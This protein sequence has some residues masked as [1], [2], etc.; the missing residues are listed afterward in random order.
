[1]RQ[2]YYIFCVLFLL[3]MVVPTP[4]QYRFDRWTTDN[5][6]P[7][8]T[9]SQIVQTS[10]GYL[11]FTTLDG[12]V[13]FDGVRFTVFNKSNSKNLPSNRFINLFAE[14][15]DTLWISTEEHGLVR[16]RHGE[17]QN[18]TTADGLPFNSNS[19]V[20]I[21][22]DGNIYAR[23]ASSLAR[24]DGTRFSLVKSG[25]EA[26]RSK[27]FY[28]PSGA[29]W[30]I[31]ENSLSVVRNGEKSVFALSPG[32]KTEFHPNYNFIYLVN[33]FEDRD[34]ALWI[35]T[36]NA[37]SEYDSGKL[38]KFAGGKFEQ[39]TADGMPKSLAYKMVQDRHGNLWIGTRSDGACRLAQ[40]RFTCYNAKNQ[41]DANAVQGIFLDR[42]GTLWLS[43]DGGGLYRVGEQFI[44]SLS[45]KEGLAKK[46][47]YPIY[48]DREGAIWIGSSGGLARYKDGK[49]TNYGSKEGLIASEIQSLFE[50]REGRLWIGGFN[51]FYYLKDGNFLGWRELMTS[52]GF[53]PTFDIHQDRRGILWFATTIGLIRYDGSSFKKFT[54]DDGLPGN[55]VKIILENDDGTFWLGT[56]SGLALM[57]DDKFTVYTDKDGLVGN[58]I[59]SLYKDETGTLWI[60][61]YDSGLSR[62]KDGKFTNYTIENGLASN[63]VFQ[64][65][66]DARRNFWISSNQGIY[67]VNR[68]E[69][70]EFAEGRRQF[71]TSTLYGKSDGMLTTEANGGGQP[72]GLKTK[73]GRLWFPTQD[74]VAVIDPEA[75]KVNPLP[76]PV[77]IENARIDNQ[78]IGGL[79]NGIEMLPGQENLE[80]DYTGLS[81]IRPEQVRFRYRLEGFDEKWTEAGSRRTAFF[82]H[83]APGEYTFQVIAANSDNVW[84]DQGAKIYIIVKPPFYRRWWFIG[85][86]VLLATGI[87]FTLYR[88]RVSQLEKERA[89][90]QAF[91]R[92]LIASQ[93]KERKRIAAELHD[94]LG[95][96]L[97]V[98]K[99]LAL[100]FLNAKNGGAAAES[101]QIEAISSEAS[102][103][104]GEVKEISYNL[105]PYQLDRI[106]LTKAI[107]AI[108]RSAQAASE[109]EF[110]S[111]IDDIDDYF[112]RETEINFYRIV[113]E[114]VNNLVKH[115]QA[116]AAIVKIRR[117]GDNLILDI[118]DN[119]KGFTPNQTESKTG[120]F[121]LIGIVERVELFGGRVEIKS[122]PG[123]G[124]EI[125]VR[126]NSRDF[127]QNI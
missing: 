79:T 61:T 20:R 62:F 36:N 22:L 24:F 10:D 45:T 78:K 7:Q 70:N 12:L 38:F 1:M 31:D 100:M 49:I 66:E 40:N 64:I 71:V 108:V 88:R 116:A 28:A 17:F 25:P 37:E 105:R 125:R 89:A 33:L 91:S 65:L 122:A 52:L 86:T 119:G 6:L 44:T 72:A 53:P 106:G 115:S 30:E 2:K 101:E 93:E 3:W 111:E 110:S 114:C 87:V 94:S 51:G 73:D 46:N 77:V 117:S 113:Q 95:Q 43:S 76:P 29:F 39:I 47:V 59:R 104:I 63:G 55:S 68:D 11:W 80:I 107:E 60:G 83:L 54:T 4:A 75:F 85:L 34:G 13:R 16:F 127:L 124:T 35:A 99:N 90:Q 8:N 23:N 19:E 67:R 9:V 32:L 81:F 74:G 56:Q 123:Q 50:D 21:N 27:W 5:G 98:I 41:L 18:F 103:A 126:L 69:L 15:D 58:Y 109:I 14:A 42:E 82:P 121:G 96:R 120:G 118:N 92:Q 97:V 57:K 26:N 84:N 112:P 102:Q 48:E